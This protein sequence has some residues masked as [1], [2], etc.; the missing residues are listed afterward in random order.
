VIPPND[1]SYERAPSR[2]WA[3]GAARNY[4]SDPARAGPVGGQT[5]RRG[6]VIGNSDVVV[7]DGS[8]AE[9]TSGGPPGEKGLACSHLSPPSLALCV[10][11]LECMHA[12]AGRCY[13]RTL[14][15]SIYSA[16]GRE[17]ERRSVGHVLYC[18]PGRAFMHACGCSSRLCSARQ[19]R[20]HR[21]LA[22]T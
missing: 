17:G 13:R 12:D 21:P 4:W 15:S 1:R 5:E 18:E 2:I 3:A 10:A 7:D 16:A 6:R 9:A 20:S 8:A 11:R 19:H 22:S 14:S